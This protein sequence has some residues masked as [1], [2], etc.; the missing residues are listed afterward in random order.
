MPCTACCTAAAAGAKARQAHPLQARQ[1]L[2][3]PPINPFSPGS[4]NVQYSP[5]S[6]HAICTWPEH[7]HHRH[8]PT[9]CAVRMCSTGVQCGVRGARTAPGTTPA[10]RRAIPRAFAL[11]HAQART[12]KHPAAPAQQLVVHSREAHALLARQLQHDI[13]LQLA[14]HQ[15]GKVVEDGRAAGVKLARVR[16]CEAAAGRPQRGRRRQGPFSGGG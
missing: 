13:L 3:S 10:P 9:S 1:L 14:R 6:T 5:K 4:T 7:A 2:R 12:L 16:V 11:P 8:T 15:L